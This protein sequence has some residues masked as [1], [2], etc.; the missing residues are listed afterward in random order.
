M[1]TFIS[2]WWHIIIPFAMTKSLKVCEQILYRFFFAKVDFFKYI[3][4]R[5]ILW[6]DKKLIIIVLLTWLTCMEINNIINVL[7]FVIMV[8][9]RFN[10]RSIIINYYLDGLSLFFLIFTL[11]LWFHKIF[12]LVYI[13]KSK[14]RLRYCY[15]V[16]NIMYIMY[17]SLQLN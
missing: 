6:K 14:N 7:R 11:K 3:L 9:Y 8:R 12:S 13:K 5:F 2:S 1:K 4:L 10:F 15:D 16:Y 17:S